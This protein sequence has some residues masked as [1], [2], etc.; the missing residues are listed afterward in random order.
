MTFANRTYI[1]G[2]VVRQ[3]DELSHLS[4]FATK[5]NILNIQNGGGESRNHSQYNSQL[6]SSICGPTDGGVNGIFS[7]ESLVTQAESVDYEQVLYQALVNEGKHTRVS[8]VSVKEV[9]PFP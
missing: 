4:E 3:S 5:M 7:R 6:P 9:D 8:K 2:C 1:F